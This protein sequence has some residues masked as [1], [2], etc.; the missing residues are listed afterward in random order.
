MR[1]YKSPTD[2]TILLIEDDE[3]DVMGVRRA[4]DDYGLTNPIEVVPNGMDALEKL[5]AGSIK[6]PY[7]V[8]LDLNMPRMN[9]IEF[10]HII[11][12]DPM[13]QKMIVFVLTTSRA[14]E[15]KDKAYRHNVAGYLTKDG[16]SGGYINA[17]HLLDQYA[18]I[19]ELP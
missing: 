1:N 7:L 13:L 17:A 16:A 3:V 5:R 11:R 4:F 2:I 6:S 9:G 12:N 18:R 10:L 14:P 19:V 15:D 8:L